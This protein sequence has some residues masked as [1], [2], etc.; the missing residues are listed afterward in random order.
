[1]KCGS[2]RTEGQ[3]RW[4]RRLDKR[5]F[6]L[7]GE[8]LW[9]LWWPQKSF[10][11]AFLDVTFTYNLRVRSGLGGTVSSSTH[12]SLPPGSCSLPITA[13]PPKHGQYNPPPDS[14]FGLLPSHANT[15]PYSSPPP[16]VASAPCLPA[17]GSSVFMELLLCH[18]QPWGS[19]RA[20]L[21]GEATPTL[22]TYAQPG[23]VTAVPHQPRNLCFWLQVRWG[24]R[25]TGMSDI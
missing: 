3:D 10:F 22:G 1:M 20:S 15:A 7:C 13:W 6:T 2:D 16:R 8:V 23:A 25:T 5:L 9:G 14:T 18:S 17:A 21:D 19:G 4:C 11:P 12:I 24:A